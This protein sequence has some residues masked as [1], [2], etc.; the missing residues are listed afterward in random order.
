MTTYALDTNIISHLL[1]ENPVVKSNIRDALTARNELIIPP[2]V[3][4]EVRRGLFSKETPVQ[5]A[6]FDRFCQRIPVGEHSKEA[7]DV[8]AR[9]Y[10][11]LRGKGNLIEDADI[12]IAAFCMDGG[13]TLVSDNTRHFD[14]VEGLR[15]VNWVE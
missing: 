4:Y 5:T 15:L 14:R 6:S 10:A 9:I 12:L 13:Y 8:A 11:T 1:K 7:L 3:Y 2:L